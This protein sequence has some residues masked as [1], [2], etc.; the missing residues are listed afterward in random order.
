MIRFFPR[1]LSIVLSAGVVFTA[2]SNNIMNSKIK[3]IVDNIKWF[4]NSAIEI[5]HNNKVIYFDI[6]SDGPEDKADLILFTHGQHDHFNAIALRNIVDTDTKIVS[7]PSCQTPSLK[8]YRL[9]LIG[10][11]PGDSA[12]FDGIK[13]KSVYAYTIRNEWQK[14]GPNSVGYILTIDG[15]RIYHAGDTELIPE[16]KDIECD[17]ALIPI[18][19]D[20]TMSS[21]ENAAQA[22]LDVKAKVAIPIHWG[23]SEY[24]TDSVQ[25]FRNL[26]RAKNIDCVVKDIIQ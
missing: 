19:Q 3:L 18:G 8:E 4:D 9:P 6:Y 7:P 2:F 24:N 5:T 21:I 26:L 15:I 22:V 25:R 12:E 23:I 13:I 16:M 10:M 17:I 1:F 20:H 11:I 14:R